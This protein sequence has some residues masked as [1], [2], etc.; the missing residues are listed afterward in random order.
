MINFDNALG[1]GFCLVVFVE[2]YGGAWR[3]LVADDIEDAAFMERELTT[4]DTAAVEMQRYLALA[5][6][7]FPTA[8]GTTP[9]DALTQLRDRLARVSDFETWR[10]RVADA[11]DAIGVARR[12]A[13]GC[14]DDWIGRAYDDGR[15]RIID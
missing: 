14:E 12:E 6:P 10:A 5:G 8:T 9:T 4:D 1:A 15:L 7:L 3:A 11:Y 13:A 2:R